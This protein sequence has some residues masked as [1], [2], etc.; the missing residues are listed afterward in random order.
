MND[1]GEEEV[2]C[3]ASNLYVQPEYSSYSCISQYGSSVLCK[4]L[5]PICYKQ[6]R[7]FLVDADI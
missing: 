2:F 3:T 7:E 4:E 1:K 5:C 6:F